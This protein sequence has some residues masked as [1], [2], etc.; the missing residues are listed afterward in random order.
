MPD[1]AW[2][3][4][5]LTRSLRALGAARWLR[6][7]DHERL[8]TPFLTARRNAARA[9]T[10]EG[11][12]SAFDAKRLRQAL[13]D[14]VEMIAAA[15]FPKSP[16]DR[17]AYSAQ[18]IDCGAAVWAALQQ[19]AAC[20]A[21]V[22]T[23]SGDSRGTTWGSW[24]DALRSLYLAADAWWMAMVAL[25]GD[26]RGGRT[27][28]V[29]RLL[30][31]IVVATFTPALLRAQQHLTY[32]VTGVSLATLQAN[33]FDVVGTEGSVSLIVADP[34]ELARLRA[35]GATA[36]LQLTPGIDQRRIRQMAAVSTATTVYRSYDDPRRGIR[37]WVDSLV[38]ANPRVSVDTVGRSYEGRPILAVKIGPRGDAS[39]R[40]NVLFVATHHAR[41]WA[42]TE[43]A[44][45]LIRRLATA[46]DARIDSLV[47]ARDI[48]IVPVVN[49]DGYE[50]TFTT[51]RLWRKNRRPQGGG[52][53]GVDL[54]RNH[55]V[56]WGL[57]NV[58]S[59]PTPAS[60]TYRGAAPAS[61]PEVL[62]L[63]T[64]H[65]THPPVIS[66]SY[67]TYAGLLLFPPGSQYGVLSAD[68]DA[69][70]VLAGT[71]VASAVIDR[72]PSSRRSFYAPATAWMLY[73]TNGEYTDWASTTFGTISINPEVTSGY[74]PSGYYGFE[75]PDDNT[76]LEQ[77][78]T[79][80]LPFALDAIEMAGNPAAYRSPTTGLRADRWVLESGTPPLRMR[81]PAASVATATVTAGG[82]PV[83]V[84][85][86]SGSG[87]KYMRRLI[88]RG[89]V[90]ARPSTITVSTGSSR[91]TWSLVTAV[92]AEPGDSSWVLNGFGSDT[93]LRMTGRASYRG[94]GNAELRSLPFVVPSFADTLSVTFWTRY[95]G[96]GYS[97]TPY[98]VARY[99]IDDGRTWTNMARYA[100][101]AQAW[102]PEDVRIAG[103]RNQ[104]VL[105]SFQTVGLPWWIDDIAI[106]AHGE[107]STRGGEQTSSA[108]LLPSANPVRGTSVTFTW[109]FAG[110]TGR[111]WV[112]D[113]TGRMIWTYAVPTGAI[114]ATWTLGSSVPNGVYLVLA[115]SAGARAR[116]KLFVAREAP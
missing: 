52:A 14:S 65:A 22:L 87:G 74:G 60:E 21:Q 100:G 71:N 102:Y 104:R 33:G 99:S 77:L 48:W 11:Q 55:S 25:R 39:S 18:V 90:A 50:Y 76:L 40:P 106:Y 85:V 109:P 31:W 116:L 28:V 115:E 5:E 103:V 82:Q 23:A 96:D 69:Y 27:R 34:T 44:L 91:A 37:A 105:L 97:E 56:S 29:N 111:L 17:R 46:T 16:A 4:P 51:D 20:E 112:Y 57:D 24:V 19:L 75:F 72:L 10:V 63:Q 61:E 9:H 26:A 110:R 68:L 41:E 67:H 80:N 79:D 83:S 8:F 86:D 35:S 13:E 42:A 114:D 64:W 95:S 43:T 73:P 38:T 98:G 47:N 3:V 101:G 36:E 107:A 45:R 81:G 58:G 59:S 62:A 108:R 66:I 30:V 7:P 54:N 12:V 89:G 2:K 93:T 88:S 84:T 6:D 78:F 49:P 1:G 53:I 113:L 70:R 32:R 94:A 92:G 15:R